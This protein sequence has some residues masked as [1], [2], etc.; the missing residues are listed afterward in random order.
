VHG[1]VGENDTVL[2]DF[3]MLDTRTDPNTQVPLWT[4]LNTANNVP[5]PRLRHAMATAA[6]ED[7]TG[8]VYVYGGVNELNQV[9]DDLHAF[10]I[11]IMSWRQVAYSGGPEA[12]VDHS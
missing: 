1:G 4:D 10:N 2:G 3:Y 11:G 8:F 12:R 5:S 7:G 6:S 9:M